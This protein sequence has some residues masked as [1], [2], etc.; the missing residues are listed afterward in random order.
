MKIKFSCYTVDIIEIPGTLVDEDKKECFGT[1]DICGLKIVVE[2]NRVPAMVLS[3]Y[4]H[5][6]IEMVDRFQ[7]IG[8]EHHQVA[9]IGEGLAQLFGRNPNLADRI[10]ELS[11]LI[12]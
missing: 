4:F 6:L 3:T 8:L 9:S 12:K 11:A 5:E 2:G 7:G 1:W 10:L